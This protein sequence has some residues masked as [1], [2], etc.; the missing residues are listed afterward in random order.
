MLVV[1]ARVLETSCRRAIMAAW[2]IVNRLEEDVRGGTETFL[3]E[4]GEEVQLRLRGGSIGRGGR[5][6]F[7]VMDVFGYESCSAGLQL[8]ASDWLEFHP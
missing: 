2:A 6:G 8:W 7:D 4:R 1:G 3:A 5:R